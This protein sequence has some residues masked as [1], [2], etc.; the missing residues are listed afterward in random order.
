MAEVE[1]LILERE[2]KLA[3]VVQEEKYILDEDSGRNL[4]NKL[5]DLLES[6]FELKGIFNALI[7]NI[8]GLNQLFHEIPVEI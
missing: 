6:V 7:V 3:L 2:L 4:V 8:L 5:N 1:Y